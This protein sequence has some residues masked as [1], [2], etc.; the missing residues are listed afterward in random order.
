MARLIFATLGAIFFMCL[1]KLGTATVYNVGDT[2]GWDTGV[3]YSS[4]ASGKTFALGD[5]LG[6]YFFSCSSSWSL[7]QFNLPSSWQS[8]PT[9]LERTQ[10]TKCRQMTISHVR[11]A[12]ISARTPAARRRS[13]SRPPVPI[14]SSAEFPAIASAAWSSP[15]QSAA[16]LVL[17]PVP[18]PRLPPPPPPPATTIPPPAKHRF[19]RRW[20]A[21]WS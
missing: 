10:W 18:P 20:P 5:S 4:W 1:A 15:S 9:G 19:L 16:P 3:D 14:T 7:H 17:H 2:S 21:C 11:R 12:T 13:L 8:S 6:N